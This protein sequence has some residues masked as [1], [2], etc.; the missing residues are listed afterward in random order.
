MDLTKHDLFRVDISE[1][2]DYIKEH[3]G[4]E[5]NC[6]DHMRYYEDTDIAVSLYDVTNVHEAKRI[7]ADFDATRTFRHTIDAVR[8]LVSIGKLPLGFYEF[9]Q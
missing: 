6:Y 2:S 5:F 9:M 7:Q 8:Y 4:V 3:L 1:L